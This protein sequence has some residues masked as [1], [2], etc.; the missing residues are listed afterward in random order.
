MH[1]IFGTGDY[2]RTS[3]IGCSGSKTAN[4]E[5]THVILGT[6]IYMHGFAI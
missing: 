2:M 4:C 1:V 5:S 6:E 3:L